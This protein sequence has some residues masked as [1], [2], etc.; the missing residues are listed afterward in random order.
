MPS[1]TKA[2]GESSDSSSEDK[3]FVHKNLKSSEKATH[4]VKTFLEGL[5]DADSGPEFA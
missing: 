1:S 3:F 4:I 5:T 2:E